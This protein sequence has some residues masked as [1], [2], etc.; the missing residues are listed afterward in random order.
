MWRLGFLLSIVGD[1]QLSN[2]PHLRHSPGLANSAKHRS[3]RGTSATKC[4]CVEHKFYI[5]FPA[6]NLISPTAGATN[7]GHKYIGAV[8]IRLSRCGKITG[9]ALQS[10]RSTLNNWTR[11]AWSLNCAGS[12]G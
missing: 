1:G 2:H 4:S 5:R 10:A 6:R 9:L 8:V 3:P 12:C 7:L 11:P